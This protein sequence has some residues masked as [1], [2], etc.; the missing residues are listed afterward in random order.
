MVLRGLFGWLLNMRQS[1]SK[2]HN[3]GVPGTSSSCLRCTSK[4]F[5]LSQ[6]NLFEEGATHSHRIRKGDGGSIISFWTTSVGTSITTQQI[7]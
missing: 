3:Q 4:H 7:P 1:W 2:T 6:R 5:L